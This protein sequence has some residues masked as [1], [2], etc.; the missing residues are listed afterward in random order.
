VPRLRLSN[1]AAGR[2]RRVLHTVVALTLAALTAAALQVPQQS[3]ATAA[4]PPGSPPNVVL[5][6]T[7]DMTASDLQYMPFTRRLLGG[8]GAT[9]TDAVSPYPLCC[10]ARATILSGQLSHNHGVVSNDSSIG[11]YEAFKRS[12]HYD[13]HLGH[14]LQQ[15]G[16]RTMFVGKYLNHYGRNEVVP[17]GWD[18]WHALVNAAGGSVYDYF[19]TALQETGGGIDARVGEYQTEV[20]GQITR[21]FIEQSVRGRPEPFFVWESDLAPHGAC[22]PTARGCRWGPP[23]AMRQDRDRFTGLRITRPRRGSFNERVVREKPQHIRRLSTWRPRRVARMDEFFRQRVRSLQAVDRSVQETVATLRR[24]RVLNK[25]LIIF[26]S[27]NGYLIGHHRWHGKV[28]PYEPSLRIPLLMRGPGVPRGVRRADTA[29]L[30][31]VAPTIMD[32]AGATPAI[33]PDGQSL[34][35]VAARPRADGY[36]ALSIEAGPQTQ[37]D[38]PTWFYRGVRTRRYTYVHYPATREYELYD[39]RSDPD[40]MTNVAYRPAY[41]HT[42]AAL[43]AK[44]ALLRDCAGAA[45]YDVDGGGVPEPLPERYLDSG[46]TV[47]P[48][49]L[50]SIGRASQVVTITARNWRTGRGRLTAWTRRGRTWTVRR[51]PIDVRLGDN[52]MVQ[53]RLHRRGV[54][55]TPAGTY[56]PERAFGLQPRPAT[57]VRYDRVGRGDYWVQDPGVPRAYNINQPRRTADALWRVSHAVRWADYP[58]R[59]PRALLMDYNLPREVAYSERYDELR[60]GVPADVHKGSFILHVGRRLG[61]HGWVSMPQRSLTWLLGWMRLRTQRTTFVVGTPR[62]LRGRL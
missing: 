6:T 12:P 27:D 25:T 23:M 52:G 37:E 1:R 15:A 32:A 35:P 39:R 51:G 43:E 10:P 19:G 24:L 42:R 54:G 3:V 21:N 57:S 18:E 40:Q 46:A 8:Q 16:Y 2:R 34:L 7:D 44:L 58:D 5:I 62:Y 33:E 22:H 28:L 26:T 9:F 36:G 11:G 38:W 14:W 53:Q 45:C 50:G 59:F 55:E 30:V 56:R 17:P 49:E 31:D 4:P 48:D 60:A 13:G 61:R 20:F 47:H 41:E 29:A